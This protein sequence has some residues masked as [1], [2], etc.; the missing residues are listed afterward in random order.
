NRLAAESAIGEQM[1]VKLVLRPQWGAVVDA[2][3][4]GPLIVR[5]GQPVF[6]ALEDFA[7]SQIDPRNPRTAVGQLA[8]GRIVMVAVDGRS[9]YSAGGMTFETAQQ[10]SPLGAGTGT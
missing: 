9:G 10:F 7:P 2:I 3:G 4:G 1:L 5:D 6:S 8:D